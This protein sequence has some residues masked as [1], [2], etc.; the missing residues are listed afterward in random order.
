[1]GVQE[2]QKRPA[3]IARP[4]VDRDRMLE[5]RCS[6]RTRRPRG[7]HAEAYPWRRVDANYETQSDIQI[8]ACW[9]CADRAVVGVV[10]PDDERRRAE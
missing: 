2:V 9:W 6:R 8:L 3:A 10:G 4:G 7:A 1:M 5:R